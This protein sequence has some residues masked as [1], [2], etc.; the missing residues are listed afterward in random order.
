[1]DKT[2]VLLASDFVLPGTRLF[3]LL[4]GCSNVEVVGGNA[5]VPGILTR[6]KEVKPHVLILDVFP[7]DRGALAGI[8]KLREDVPEIKV[9]ALS[10]ATDREFVLRVLRA[11][12]HSYL[13][14]G[15]L[16][17]QLVKAVKAVARG[18]V[19]LCPYACNALL[20][21]YHRRVRARK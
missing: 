9:I 16:E 14:E 3:T 12:V 11:G 2:R 4:V 19:F 1:M 7:Q 10:T 15:D 13:L 6:A 21:G 20:A 5:S 17:R 18:H 8:K